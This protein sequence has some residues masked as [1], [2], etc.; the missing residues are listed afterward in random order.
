MGSQAVRTNAARMIGLIVVVVASL[1]TSAP[2]AIEPRTI[3]K[4]YF[5]TGDV[6]TQEQFSTLIDSLVTYTDDRYLIGLRVYDP[7]KTYL[8]GDTA[9][10]IKRFGIGDTTPTSP[11][12]YTDP[13]TTPIAMQPD[14]GGQFGF[15][16][17]ML[18]DS[19]G[20]YYGFLQIQMDSPPGSG[21]GGVGT[22]SVP[23]GPAI[24]VQYL[25]FN[26]TPNT[27][28]TMFVVPEPGS[29]ALALFA[30]TP[31]LVRRDRK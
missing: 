17:M 27:P 11:L 13:H 19:A 31:L 28:I 2:G 18:Q 14:F 12:E 30:I 9:I 5:E 16:A 6:P 3:L 4:S 23:P 1:A 22:L 25:A 10:A 21:G 29:V 8:P 20:I 24:H 7:T 26:S 15:A